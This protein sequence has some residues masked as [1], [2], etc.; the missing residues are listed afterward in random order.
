MLKSTFPDAELKVI[1]PLISRW[2]SNMTLSGEE[3]TDRVLMFT[4]SGQNSEALMTYLDW[5][6]SSQLNH[7]MLE[8][9][10]YGTQLMYNPVE[11]EYYYLGDYSPD[12]KPYNG[13]YT[14]GLATEMLYTSPSYVEYT[15]D[16][17]AQNTLKKEVQEYMSGTT[18]KFPVTVELNDTA[19]TALAE[20]TGIV[21]TASQQ[22]IKGE[23]TIDDYAQ[24]Q[25]NI[26]NS[27][28]LATLT[29]EIGVAYLYKIGALD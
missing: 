22:Y 7:T 14:F 17:M 21:T 27:G 26:R 28:L 9:G 11:N 20:Y 3:K 8:L 25:R 15:N 6:Y 19:K 23:I 24:Y 16:I 12:N 10:A 4:Q 29:Q 5:A 18:C 2:N 13:L 1:A